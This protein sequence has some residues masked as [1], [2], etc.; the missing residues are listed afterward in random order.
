[1]LQQTQVDRVIPVYERF[2]ERFPSLTDLAA[3]PRSAV[4]DAWAGL[5]YNRRAVYLHDL[6]REVCDHHGGAIPADR[7]TLLALPGIGPY[8]AGAILSIGFGQDEHAVDTNIE[9]VL[10]RYLFGQA[11]STPE[12]AEGARGL[13]PSGSA[14]DWNQA[15]MDLGST[16]CKARVPRCL[17][18]PLCE[19]C[20]GAGLAAPIPKRAQ[21]RFTDSTRYYRGR[22]LAE[23]RA[24]GPQSSEPLYTAAQR[25]AGRGIAEPAAGWDSVARGLA[26]D[27]L[28]ALTESDDG[29]MIG[30]PH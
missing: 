30:L 17:L 8:T 18:C 21:S 4:I 22:L 14:R 15:L 3:A 12:L 29:P 13:V 26:A 11:A 2:L 19:G 5:G 24:L 7:E 28:A 23:L 25:L 27:G 9:R 1:M 10:S 6:A 20:A 16:I